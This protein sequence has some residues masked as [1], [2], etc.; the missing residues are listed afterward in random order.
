M[1]EGMI[2]VYPRHDDYAEQA[3]TMEEVMNWWY[4]QNK[5]VIQEIVITEMM[6]MCFYSN[7]KND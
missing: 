2:K 1:K 7:L 3:K 5:S 6:E 4:K